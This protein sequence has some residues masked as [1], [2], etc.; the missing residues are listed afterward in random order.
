MLRNRN[1]SPFNK[2]VLNSSAGPLVAGNLSEGR[3]SSLVVST[4][5]S[6]GV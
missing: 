6:Q 4:G 3:V 5:Q 2:Y 1:A